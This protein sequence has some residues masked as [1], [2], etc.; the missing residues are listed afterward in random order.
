MTDLEMDLIPR[1]YN[2]LFFLLNE[3]HVATDL[4]TNISY[5][6]RFF[7]SSPAT[8]HYKMLCNSPL[9][10]V[11]VIFKPFGAYRLLGIPQHLLKD[12]FTDMQSIFSNKIG[13][14]VKKMEDQSQNPEAIIQILQTWLLEQQEKLKFIFSDKIANACSII[15][16]LPV[17]TS[18]VAIAKSVS[19]SKRS[20]E[21]HFKEQ[22]GIS[23]KTFH[24]V[25]RFSKIQEQLLKYTT[26]DWQ[27]IVFDF[28]YF[29]QTHFIKEFK[30]F[31]GYTPTRFHQR[32]PDLADILPE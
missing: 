14:L 2:Q 1:G 23:P 30:Q 25:T 17:N 6:A 8:R 18:L 16:E 12:D 9:E 15:T 27:E 24:R 13:D 7:I 4:D 20:M 5:N 10:S 21:Q 3:N 26:T 29:D 28:G 31:S 11:G 32:K 19:M 22:V